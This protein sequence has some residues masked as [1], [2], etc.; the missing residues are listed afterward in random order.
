MR[1][2]REAALPTT[3]S[4]DSARALGLDRCQ[5]FQAI[6]PDGRVGVVAGVKASAG[7]G[8]ADGIVIVTGLYKPHVLVAGVADVVSVRRDR[9]R[10]MLS[11]NPVEMSAGTDPDG[12]G[13]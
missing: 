10:V 9:K 13:R 11:R 8:P 5:G 12:T 1:D 2:T 3:A 6:G 7:H 4:P